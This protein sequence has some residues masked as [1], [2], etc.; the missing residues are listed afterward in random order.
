MTV[1]AVLRASEDFDDITMIAV[2][3]AAARWAAGAGRLTRYATRSGRGHRRAD[4]LRAYGELLSTG[5][6]ASDD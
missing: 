5:S 6:A 2:V 3:D 1:G 4:Q